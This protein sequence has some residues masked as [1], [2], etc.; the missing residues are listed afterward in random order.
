MPSPKKIS[1]SL[2]DDVRDWLA[3]EAAQL[4]CDAATLAQM[5]V[6]AARKRGPVEIP[7]PAQPAL[8]LPNSAASSP[9]AAEV[10]DRTSDPDAWRGAPDDEPPEVDALRA[11]MVPAAP[12]TEMFAHRPLATMPTMTSTRALSRPP[13]P[14]LAGNQAPHLRAL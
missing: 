4:G 9:A 10:A 11:H 8:P 13:N 1:L 14:Y 2:S 3:A 5:L 6:V 12:P 7:L